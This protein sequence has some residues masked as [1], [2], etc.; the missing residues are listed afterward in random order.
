MASSQ[1]ALPRPRLFIG[2][3]TSGRPIAE[4]L[5]AQ[6]VGLA[7]VTTWCE[8]DGVAAALPAYDVAAFVLDRL[9]ERGVLVQLGVLLGALGP[10]RVVVLPVSGVAE[11]PYPFQDLVIATHPAALADRVLRLTTPSSSSLPASPVARRK[12][13]SLGI[14][15]SDRPGQTLR[16]ADISVTGALLETFGEIPE[17]QTLEL[18]LTLENG[19]SI[20]VT[21]KVVRI[22]YPQ[23]GRVGG[24]GV[25]FTH[26][27][28]DA[29]QVLEKYVNDE[30]ALAI[31]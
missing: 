15:C 8:G 4:T 5:R 18:N 21:A 3:G 11:L 23:W 22:Q 2:S 30:P 16:I 10:E 12:R 27:A 25:A 13:R 14:A 7:N 26:F 17:N 6:L 1:T 28:G 20:G 31:A 24:V 29:L 9:P 19:R